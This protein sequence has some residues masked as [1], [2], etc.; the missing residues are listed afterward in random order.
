MSHPHTGAIA[1]VYISSKFSECS[2]N[3]LLTIWA[4]ISQSNA[5]FLLE[6]LIAYLES[7]WFTDKVPA[8]P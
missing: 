2:M 5:S 3:M 7:R 8:V 6:E 4:R 1:T